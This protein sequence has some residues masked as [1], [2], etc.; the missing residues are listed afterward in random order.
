M[1]LSM[2][3]A[4]TAN[5]FC[6]CVT[7]RVRPVRGL[8]GPAP[9]RWRGVK[10]TGSR[11]HQALRPNG[12]GTRYRFEAEPNPAQLNLWRPRRVAADLWVQWVPEVEG[13]AGMGSETRAARPGA[14]N[15]RF[16]SVSA[17]EPCA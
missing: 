8:V 2:F 11:R 5:W 4:R 1:A 17:L 12:K 13:R 10:A 3:G 16:A 15:Q 14:R 9:L 7:G 6:T